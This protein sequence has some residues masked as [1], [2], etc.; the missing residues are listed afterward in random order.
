M[1]GWDNFFAAQ[2]GASAALTG[3]VFVGV[4][5]NLTKIMSFPYLPGLAL[6]A[7]VVLLAVLIESSLLLTPGQST[8]LRGAEVGVVG[9]S[10]WAITTAVQ[11]DNYQ[12]IEARYRR[13]Y[14]VRLI[15]LVQL[16]TLAFVVASAAMLL[17][18]A[19][20]VYW[21]VPGTIGCYLVAISDAWILLIEI[22]R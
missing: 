2:V 21:V 7:V 12:K 4:S 17:R 19:N 8:A 22:N 1:S 18:G 15:V 13:A 10:V 14:A 6:E 3:L 11:R 20:G 5:I 16:A 9:L